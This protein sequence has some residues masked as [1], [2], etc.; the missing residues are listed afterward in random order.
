MT[1]R[2]ILAALSVAVVWGLTFIAIKV[3][4][5]ETTPLMLA[6]LRFFFAAVPMVFFLPP[7]KA[8]AWAVTVYGLLIG[9]G[10]FGLLFIAI[11]QGFPVGLAS[12]VI[13]AQVFF[14]ILLAWIW[15]GERPRRAQIVGAAVGFI[16]MAVIGSERLAGAT[17]A[18]FLL[19]ILAGAFWGSANVLAKSVGKVDM[20][21]FT[22]WSSLAAPLPLF[23]LSLAIEGTGGLAGLAHPGLKLVV[24]VLVISYAGTVFGYGL[25]TRLMA[26]YSAA[27]VAPFA[28]LVPVVGMIA[29]ALLFGEAL[30]AIELVGGAL[31]MAGLALNV[32][33]DWALRRRLPAF[34]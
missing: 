4:V 33:G 21:A 26:R 24:S 8:P 23:A 7:P 22:V 3:G 25:W 34:R 13:M 31:V 12:L 2:D 6:A 10:Q 16:G 18:P 27:T 5:G 20:L 11:H 19:V 17:L 9:V 1:P 32:F 15:L 28:L 14:T 30:S 29:G